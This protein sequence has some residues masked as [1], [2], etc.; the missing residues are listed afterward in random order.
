MNRLLACLFEFLYGPLATWYD[1][2][3]RVGFAGEWRRWQRAVLSFVDDGPLL[4]LGVGTGE[5]LPHL[6]ATGFNP[7][8]LD[9]SARMVDIARRKLAPRGLGNRL[10]RGDAT[11]L[12]FRAEVFGGVVATFPSG[13][14]VAPETWREVERVLRPGGRFAVALDGVLAPDSVGRA[15]RASV[16]RLLYGRRPARLLWNDTAGLQAREIWAVTEH[17]KVRLLLATKCQRE[18]HNLRE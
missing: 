4:E 18:R 12:P 5:L 7:V 6:A 14:I 17:G 16:F 13:Y 9:R 10:V 2:I 1:I 11:A 8:G 3:S 15:L